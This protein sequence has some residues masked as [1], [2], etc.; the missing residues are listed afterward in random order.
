MKI[1]VIIATK[2]RYQFLL[3]SLESVKKQTVKP[4]Q[5]IVTSDSHD[6]EIIKEQELCEKYDAIWI[7]NKFSHN[8]AGNLNTALVYY[9]SNSLN[10]LWDIQNTYIAFLDDDDS[11]K[12]NYLKECKKIIS[13]YPYDF[14]VCGL[15]R[16]IN[17]KLIEHEKVDKN[18]KLNIHHFLSTNPGI[19][20]SNTFIKLTT[21]LK[22]GCFDEHLNSTTDRDLFTRVMM[23]EPKY[24]II[25]KYLVNVDISEHNRLTTNTL[26]KSQS[27]RIF[28]QKYQGLMTKKDLVDFKERALNKFNCDPSFLDSKIEVNKPT[29]SSKNIVHKKDIKIL[30]KLP[31]LLIG[32][33]IS[34]YS[35]FKTMMNEFINLDYTNKKILFITNWILSNEQYQDVDQFLKNKVKN[36]YF[37]INLE[38]I[39]QRIQTD[40]L[41]KQTVTFNNYYKIDINNL[42]KLNS[43][44]LSR[45]ILNYYLYETAAQKEVVWIID[46]DMQFHYEIYQNEQIIS[47][48]INIKQLISYYYTKSYDMVI[49]NYSNFPPVPFLSTLRTNLVDYLYKNVLLQKAY[50][51]NLSFLKNYYYDLDSTNIKNYEW[52]WYTTCTDLN[53]IF[54]QQNTTRKLFS[55]DDQYL[56]ENEVI[57]RGGNSLIF[58]KEILKIPN[59]SLILG[60]II[61]RRSDYFFVLNAKYKGFKIINT[62]FCLSH[63]PRIFY[64]YSYEKEVDKF[65]SD[66]IGY[67]FTSAYSYL[68]NNNIKIELEDFDLNK[69][70]HWLNL[71]QNVFKKALKS[72]LSLFILNYFRIIGILNILQDKNYIKDF[73]Q[74]NLDN[75][76]HKI[77]KLTTLDNLWTIRRFFVNLDIVNKLSKVD[78]YSLKIKNNFHINNELEFIASGYEG[79]IFRN[80]NECYKAF[81]ENINFNEIFD[82]TNK[83]K[84]VSWLPTI[85]IYKDC[86]IITHQ[87]IQSCKDNN[88][89]E[90]DKLKQILKIQNDLIKNKVFISDLKQDN[91]ILDKNNILHYVDFNKNF[92]SFIDEKEDIEKITKSF[93]RLYKYGN[94]EKNQFCKLLYI[95]YHLNNEGIYYQYE[96]YL[97]V[98]KFHT[99]EE[100][101]DPII[102]DS[103]K[104]KQWNKLL[105]YGAGKC[106][107]A[108]KL[109]QLFPNKQIF[110]FD[111]DNSIINQRKDKDINFINL[112]NKENLKQEFD[113]I[114]LNKVFC[115]TNKNAHKKILNNISNLLLEE[116]DLIISICNPFFDNVYPTQF[117]DEAKKYKRYDQC[118]S[119]NKKS[120]YG[121][122]KEYHYPFL[123]Y[124]RL[125]NKHNFFIKQ[126]KQDDSFTYNLNENSEHLYFDCIKH[127]KNYLSNCTL[128]IKTNPMDHEMIM[129]NILHIVNQLEKTDQF[130]EIIVIVDDVEHERNRRFSNDNL[131]V[132]KKKLNYLKSCLYIDKIYYA[133][134]YI[135]KQNEIY[136]KYFNQIVT[137]S[138]SSNKQQL[139]A[140]LLGF[141]L[142]KT[143]YVFQ[144]DC[145][146]LFFNNMKQ[147][148]SNYLKELDKNKNAL[149]LALSIDHNKNLKNTFSKRIEVRNCFINLDLLNSLLPLQNKIV[150]DQFKLAWHQSIDET[151]KK[152]INLRCISKDLYFI[153]PSNELKKEH[154]NYIAYISYLLELSYKPTKLQQD[155]VELLYLD[156]I[157]EYFL[158]LKIN[159][160]IVIF[161]HGKDVEVYK[162]LRLLNSLKKQTIQDFVVIYID[163]KSNIKSCEYLK[164]LFSYDE[165]CKSH[166]VSL[167]NTKSIKSLANFYLVIN[168]ILVNNNSIII[169]LDADDALLTKEAISKIKDAFDNNADVSVGNCF[170]TNKPTTNY[171]Q[172]NFNKP[173]LRNGDNVWLHP[174]CFLLKLAKQ[175]RLQDLMLNNK[176]VKRCTDFTMMYAILIHAKNPVFIKDLIYLYDPANIKQDKKI[177]TKYIKKRLRNKIMLKTKA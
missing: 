157:N 99:K 135:N 112:N 83:L 10:D 96:N 87:Y 1:I 79:I 63:C 38:M 95:N 69:E 21:L 78:E 111:I 9:L 85:R 30:D 22:A 172:V 59:A 47:L 64:E 176:I 108:N 121:N 120:I 7:K 74:Q 144:T 50:D 48:P 31:N 143:K 159:K 164:M 145:D 90:F 41:F 149:S 86:N 142:I 16:C 98:S 88:L 109:H 106:K 125:L 18:T 102:L 154:L 60:E 26:Q 155:K 152:L 122:R 51:K 84:N 54:N 175:I 127:T 82:A 146:I 37:W 133:S 24:F 126:I 65:T 15:N 33:I 28:Y 137:S 45:M 20:G 4:D 23:L 3:K 68:I 89:S 101:H 147:T 139:F 56:T 134:E 52:S 72:R 67:S 158:K 119:F 13:K 76:V 66:L 17:E 118:F 115:C 138:I 36:Q 73:N 57:N 14:V 93:Y 100:I 104:Q 91:F 171:E 177:N 161:I 129:N 43:I 131:K 6:S 61:A 8:Y 132:L 46:D 42:N 173:W 110:V 81:Y 11:W 162:T 168:Q 55:E 49:G 32:V 174:K 39:K 166:I 160:K 170:N 136:L 113:L 117:V 114:L 167:F 128:L 165:W 19:Q 107:I 34:D 163:D 94:L 148:L 27:L 169:N 44:A 105:D 150:N 12:N 29:L 5:I 151:N 40:N 77:L 124:L 153:H 25:D 156:K 2:N 58:N 140:T 70:T 75:L 62:N 123:Y 92:R 80:Q 97:W 130:Y 35:L 71:F 116:K 53:T 141:S 103:I